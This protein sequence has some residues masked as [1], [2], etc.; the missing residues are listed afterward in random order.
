L[1]QRADGTLDDSTP[2]ETACLKGP[3]FFAGKGIRTLTV[4]QPWAW[5][6]MQGGKDVENRSQKT[7]IRG[8]V[9]IHAAAAAPADEQIAYLWEKYHLRAPDPLPRGVVLGTVDIIDCVEDSSSKW[10]E[11]DSWHWVLGNARPFREPRQAKGALGI[12]YWNP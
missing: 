3:N 2:A 4:R 11:G 8:T 7:S 12:W 6:I 1:E 10:A 5:A 9:A